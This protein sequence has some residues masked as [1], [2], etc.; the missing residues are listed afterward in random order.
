MSLFKFLTQAPYTIKSLERNGNGAEYRHIIDETCYF[1]R[2][3][4]D[5]VVLHMTF[6]DL[7]KVMKLAEII[8]LKD[9]ATE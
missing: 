1:A 9:L 4:T 3:S 6:K 5:G 7:E 2:R 8:E